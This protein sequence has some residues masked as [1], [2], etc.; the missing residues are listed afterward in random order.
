MDEVLFLKINSE[1]EDFSIAFLNKV[2]FVL[3]Q[4]YYV[5]IYFHLY[6]G[7]EST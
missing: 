1:D 5:L 4:K 3:F 6:L 2:L 7:D